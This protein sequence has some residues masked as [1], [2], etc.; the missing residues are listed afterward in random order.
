MECEK[1]QITSVAINQKSKWG[2][3]TAHKYVAIKG[4]SKANGMWGGHRRKGYNNFFC[5]FG[6]N[7]RRQILRY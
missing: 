5:P 3:Y 4:L 2:G 7:H 1:Y 6:W